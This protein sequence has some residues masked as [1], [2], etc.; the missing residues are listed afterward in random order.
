MVSVRRLVIAVVVVREADL[1]ALAPG[2]VHCPDVRRNEADNLE[3]RDEDERNHD[4][5]RLLALHED[6]DKEEDGAR[7]PGKVLA[8]EDNERV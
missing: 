6:R 1:A 7:G 8:E 2:L 5:D 4:L 3:A